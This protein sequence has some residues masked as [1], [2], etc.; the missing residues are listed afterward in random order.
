MGWGWGMWKM[1]VQLPIVP[2]DGGG[3][4]GKCLY[5]YLLYYGIGVGDVENVGTAAYCAMGWG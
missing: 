3:G 5:S 2:W 1:L 4:C